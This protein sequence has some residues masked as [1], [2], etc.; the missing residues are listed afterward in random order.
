MAGASK[1]LAPAPNLRFNLN[2]VGYMLVAA[3][4]KAGP[5]ILFR[6][7]SSG[8]PSWRQIE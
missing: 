2:K 5:G 6:T 4:K 1:L 7:T 3:F 8:I